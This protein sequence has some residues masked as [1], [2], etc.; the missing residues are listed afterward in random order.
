MCTLGLIKRIMHI[1]WCMHVFYL[2]MLLHTLTLEFIHTFLNEAT[3]LECDT[4]DPKKIVVGQ[5]NVDHV[6]T[7]VFT[8]SE[9]VTLSAI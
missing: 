8:H 3:G 2:H 6:C 5:L 7:D 1:R 9:M 4:A